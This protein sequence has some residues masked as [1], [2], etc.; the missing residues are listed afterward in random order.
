MHINNKSYYYQALANSAMA[1]SSQ[2]GP[3]R[4]FN[5][6]KADGGDPET[7]GSSPEPG[8][9]MSDVLNTMQGG[10]GM[11]KYLGVKGINLPP[12]QNQ[13]PE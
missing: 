11:L 5:L 2:A 10:A 1:K 13:K 6:E 8:L 3:S 7:E 12:A 9:K 4:Q